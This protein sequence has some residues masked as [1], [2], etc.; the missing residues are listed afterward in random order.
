MYEIIEKMRKIQDYLQ[1]YIED[2]SIE[3]NYSN[4]VN[5]FKNQQINS[6]RLDLKVLLNILAKISNNH[7]RNSNFFEKIEK[8]L[9]LFKKDITNYFSSYEIFKIFK[10]NKRILLY[11]IKEN[12][13]TI[14]KEII[15][16]MMKDKFRIQ[17]YP[18]YFS[19]EI[20]PFIDEEF[21]ELICTKEQNETNE[22]I[23]LINEICKEK[24]DDFE[25]NRKFGENCDPLCKIIQKDLI[26][27]FI[28]YVNKNQY[29]LDNIIDNSVFETNPLLLKKVECS[30]IQYAAFFGAI[31]IFKYLYKNGIELTPLLWIYAIHGDD[32]EI[33]SILEENKVE[34]FLKYERCIRE[35]IKCHHNH[36][37][38]YFCMNYKDEIDEQINFEE[39]FNENIMSY[40]FR[41]YNFSFIPK[42]IKNIYTFCYACQYD[43]SIVQCLFKNYQ[44][45]INEKI[46]FKLFFYAVFVCYVYQV[47]ISVI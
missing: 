38:N 46:I 25:D 2:D 13:M 35:A 8:V 33:I 4:M 7:Y 23:D 41:Y 44:I 12:I 42:E 47:I 17:R 24:P 37:V 11:L 20:K 27:E 19:P 22:E 29:S 6:N 26:E 1:V 18:E 14:D 43:F 16:I 10:K 40:C 30:L 45:D 21:K 9:S 39:N 32:S 34:F 31:Q 36:T 28:I 3:A 15:L 5:F